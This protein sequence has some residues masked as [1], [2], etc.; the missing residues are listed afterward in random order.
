M[1]EEQIK[2]EAQQQIE[3]QTRRVKFLTHELWERID[4]QVEKAIVGALDYLTTVKRRNRWTP[5][6]TIGPRSTTTQSLIKS[7]CNG[8]DYPPLPI[9]ANNKEL[10]R[11]NQPR[12]KSPLFKVA[13]SAISLKY[14][15]LKNEIK[16]AI[17]E[18]KS[19]QP[20][21]NILYR[22]E[23]YFDEPKKETLD[24]AKLSPTL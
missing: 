5:T 8:K 19:K 15:S 7:I 3:T 20:P 4:K 13:A 1:T 12:E 2:L 18:E 21:E 14:N 22:L 17:R 6:I 10:R 9:L 11:L 16:E 24:T 23:P